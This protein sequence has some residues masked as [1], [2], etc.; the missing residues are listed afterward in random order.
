MGS[1]LVVLVE[2]HLRMPWKVSGVNVFPGA[3]RMGGDVVDGTVPSYDEAIRQR[4]IT[5]ASPDL[6]W[7]P[8]AQDKGMIIPLDLQAAYQD[9][10]ERSRLP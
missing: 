4:G 2:L 7:S 1:L 10:C 8:L 9:A 3:S 6:R 5:R